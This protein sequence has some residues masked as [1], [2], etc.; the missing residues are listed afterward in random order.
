MA[1]FLVIGATGNS[2]IAII[3]NLLTNTENK[4]Q[5]VVRNITKAKDT[6]KLSYEK[7]EKVIEFEFGKTEDDAELLS[8]VQNC[9]YIISA[10]GPRLNDNPL[11]SD[12]ISTKKMIELSEKSPNLKKF[13]YISSMLVTRP[14]HPIS[15]LLNTMVPYC[16]GYKA[17]SENLFRKS[18]L[19]YIIVRPGGL[20]DKPELNFVKVDQGDKRSGQISRATLG[21]FIADLI[22]NNQGINRT[23]ID[24]ISDKT[25]YKFELPSNLKEDVFDIDYITKD[26]FNGTKNMTIL[27][28]TVLVIIMVYLMH[29]FL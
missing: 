26:H 19:N 29:K 11:V 15:F 27:I 1:R 10:L 5:I 21:R 3:N 24:V 18:K 9:D 13:I 16:L 8:S 7:I 6:F 17:L 25:E 2:G 12:Y 23:T 20:T 28:Y 4:V 22:A 14:Y